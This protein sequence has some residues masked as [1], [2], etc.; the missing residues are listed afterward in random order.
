MER[1][2]GRWNWIMLL[3][4][5]IWIS[6][7]AP[8][9]LAAPAAHLP[10]D[11]AGAILASTV[12]ITMFHAGSQ[13][14]V[15]AEKAAISVVRK[16]IRMETHIARGIGSVVAL[17]EEVLVVSHDHWPQFQGVVQADRVLFHDAEG[18][19]LA[20]LSGEEFTRQTLFKDSG[21][22][23]LFAPAG[24]LAAPV[25]PAELGVA[26]HLAAGDPVTL[27]KHKPGS[28]DQ[29][30]LLEASIQEISGYPGTS[31][32]TLRTANGESIEPGDSG[33]GIWINGRLVGNL[34][35]TIRTAVSRK[36]GGS[37]PPVLRTDQGIAAVVTGDLVNLL[38]ELQQPLEL[39]PTAE[40]PLS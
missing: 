33:G 23:V 14:V 10:P 7:C 2:E 36:N 8:Q 27:V 31:R 21:T 26:R 4:V 5:L 9:G 11:S 20:E 38:L 40:S 17:G 25:K 22:L 18:H 35:M 1:K 16:T 12:Q 6:A 32:M 30:A 28:P 15:A 19:P 24:L 29:L 13:D 39:P 37:R 34:W 3:A